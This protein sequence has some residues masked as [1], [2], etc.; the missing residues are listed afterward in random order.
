MQLNIKQQHL[1]YHSGSLAVSGKGRNT[2]RFPLDQIDTLCIDKDS[3]LDAKL[4][5]VLAEQQKSLIIEGTRKQLPLNIIVP[6][7]TRSRTGVKKRWLAIVDDKAARTALATRLVKAKIRRQRQLVSRLAQRHSISNMDVQ[8]MLTTSLH[9]KQHADV[10]TLLGIEGAW[11][12]RYFRALRYFLPAWCGFDKRNKRPPKDPVNAILSLTYTLAM[13][14]VNSALVKRGFDLAFGV[15]HEDT[16]FRPS[17]SCDLL[18]LFRPQLDAWVVALFNAGIL[19]TQHFADAEPNGAVYLNAEGK[20]R[21]YIHW[22]T[23]SAR[24]AARIERVLRQLSC[25][26]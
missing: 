24:F 20:K 2:K 13:E 23:T 9:V 5:Y 8:A 10:A 11:A 22:H 18:E 16:D 4:L 21:F 19:D 15:L 6:G 14:K 7:G 25:L 17:L 12:A 26:L 1:S 3:S